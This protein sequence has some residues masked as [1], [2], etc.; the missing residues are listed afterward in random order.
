MIAANNTLKSYFSILT[1]HNKMQDPLIKCELL[2]LLHSN[3]SDLRD[4]ALP[5]FQLLLIEKKTG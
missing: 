5:S 4:A 2:I 1:L 3:A